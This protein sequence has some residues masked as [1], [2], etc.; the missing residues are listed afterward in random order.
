MDMD[1]DMATHDDFEWVRRLPK[2][3]EAICLLLRLLDDIGGHK[4]GVSSEIAC[5]EIQKK[6]DKVRKDIKP[7]HDPAKRGGHALAKLSPQ[8][9]T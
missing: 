7:S 3:F 6:A 1:M 8:L 2:P 9:G 5:E 4:Y